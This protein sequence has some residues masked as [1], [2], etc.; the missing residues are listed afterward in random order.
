VIVNPLP[1][2]TVE[3][4]ET[5]NL[6]LTAGTGYTI[7]TASAVTSMIANDD[8]GTGN[9]S[10]TGGN[11]NDSL[12]GLAGDDTLVG[13][14]GSDTLGFPTRQ[15]DKVYQFRSDR[16][17]NTLFKHDLRIHRDIFLDE[18]E[19]KESASTI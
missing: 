10:L 16:N 11:S 9:D 15:S 17:F 12:N 18:L 4:N 1:D 14:L 5:V 3:P 2:T 19:F 7:G 8:A 6:T 13:G